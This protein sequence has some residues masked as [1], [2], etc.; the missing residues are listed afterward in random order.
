MP[1]ADQPATGSSSSVGSAGGG[2]PATRPRP[3]TVAPAPTSSRMVWVRDGGACGSSGTYTAPA[4]TTPSTH[5]TH[6]TDR[7]SSTTTG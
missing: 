5:S 2:D 1:E 3:S 6:S 4:S 7:A